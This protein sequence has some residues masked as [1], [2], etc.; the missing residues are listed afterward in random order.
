MFRTETGDNCHEHS[1]M[2]KG[3]KCQGI[4]WKNVMTFFNFHHFRC[5]FPF[6]SPMH[7]GSYLWTINDVV[8][9]PFILGTEKF[10]NNEMTF[11]WH[12]SFLVMNVTWYSWHICNRTALKISFHYIVHMINR[13]GR[14][15]CS[16]CC[17]FRLSFNWVS[18]KLHCVSIESQLSFNWISTDFLL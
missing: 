11:L 3:G 16:L 17:L 6:V 14:K 12:F 7:N 15:Y 9:I 10:A 4:S 2:D 1:V 8:D 5:K 18:I 13:T